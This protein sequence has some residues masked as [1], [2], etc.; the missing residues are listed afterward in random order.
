[1]TKMILRRTFLAGFSASCL[2]GV[3]PAAFA[4]RAARTETEVKIHPDGQVDVIHVYHLQDAKDALYQAGLI[5]TPDLT[6]LRARAQLALYTND[7]FAVMNG[8]TSV[9]LE[10]IGAEIEGDSVYIYQQGQTRSGPFAI[11]A[12]MLREL[13]HGQINSVNVIRNGKTVTLDF[14]G[15]DDL[16]MVAQD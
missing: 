4:H 1:M 10:T 2:L 5:E 11:K 12:E 7:R 14:R 8:E 9:E 13:L 6:P 16:K 3:A 15:D